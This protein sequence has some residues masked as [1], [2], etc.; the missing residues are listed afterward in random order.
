MIGKRLEVVKTSHT[1]QKKSASV[2]KLLI[3]KITEYSI[4]KIIKGCF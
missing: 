4:L 1:C 2:L 3:L